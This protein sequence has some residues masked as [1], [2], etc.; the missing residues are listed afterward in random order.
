MLFGS[1][2][3]LGM[4]EGVLGTAWP[5]MRGSLGRPVESLAWLIGLYTTGYFFSTL[6]S[7]HLASRLGVSA[8]L[9]A[10][11]ACAAVGLATYAAAG[12]WWLVLLAALLTGVGAGSVDATANSFCAMV[13]GAR[14]MNLMHAFFGFGATLGPIAVGAVLDLGRSWRVVYLVMVVMEAAV[15]LELTRQRKGFTLHHEKAN[16]V[17]DDAQ[18]M[19]RRLLGAM[20]VVFAFYVGA[21]VSYGQWS[22]SLLTEERG[23]GPGV[24]RWA[25]AGYWGSLTVGRLALGWAGSRVEPLTVLRVSVVASVLGGVVFWVDPAPGADVVALLWLGFAMAGVFPAM[26]LLTPVWL[27]SANTPRAVGYQLAASSASVIVV[28]TAIGALVQGYGL[29]VVP[30]LLLAVLVGL[31][32]ALFAASAVSAVRPRVEPR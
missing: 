10:G 9:R 5:S 16:P 26:V 29:D 28:S 18:P 32:V 19:P 27:G 25:V 13:G 12:A 11:V 6:A 8:V 22:F 2:V 4:P 30:A 31:V 24:A 7:G 23:V 17:G 14:T 21:E 15:F 1:F 3:L 20:L